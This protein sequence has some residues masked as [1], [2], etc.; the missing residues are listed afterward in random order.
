MAQ[1]SMNVALL[2]SWYSE[3][4]LAPSTQPARCKT[5]QSRRR[6]FSRLA[7]ITYVNIDFSLVYFVVIDLLE[8]PGFPFIT[9]KLYLAALPTG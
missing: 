4:K 5:K 2:R 3:K 9:L 6:V 1:F 8:L 7:P